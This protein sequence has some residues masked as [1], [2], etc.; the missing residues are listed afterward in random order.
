MEMTTVLMCLHILT[1][2][3]L[4][5]RVLSRPELNPSI[6]VLWIFIVLALPVGGVLLYL[7]VGEVHFG[8]S[9]LK[10][11]VAAEVA[12]RPYVVASGSR[13]DPERFSPAS[14]FATSI[15]GFGVTEG[16]RGELLESPAGARERLIADMD[17][18]VESI[19]V[20]YYIWLDD[21]TGRNVAAALERAAGRG[22][23]C[24]AL[25]DAVGSRA[26]L[27][28]ATWK[29]LAEAGVRT[30]VMLPLKPLLLTML[31]RR[32]DLRNHRK[33]SVIDGRVCYCG[34]QNCADSEFRVKPRF[35]PWVDI[36]LRFEGPVVRQMHLL[37]LKDWITVGG[38]DALAGIE[39]PVAG[40]TGGFE[41]QVVGTGPVEGRNITA[42]LFT[43]LIFGARHEL[44]I[45]T[46]YF[47]PGE[48]VCLALMGAARS[49]VDVTLILPRRNDSGFV[50][51]ASRSY[52]PALVGAGVKIHE[53]NGGLLHSKTL[54][55]DG[56]LAFVG[57]SNMDIRSFDLNF[58]NDILLRD[59]DLTLA[60]RDRQMEYLAASTPVDPEEVRAWP[61]WR[62]VWLNAFAVVGPVL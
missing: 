38:G 17:A 8:G 52:Y 3:A 40:F 37:F 39:G 46:P 18:A 54:T 10:R 23:R 42:Q 4:V 21:G 61:L 9:A 44:V 11:N 62:R 12:V 34:S 59:R 31:A 28:S 1:F 60:V 33:I 30:G 25:V 15:N 14:G 2:A 20:L 16:N 51:K 45:S 36:M 32:P 58:E 22:V 50:A 19:D 49:G 57:S 29:R 6:R 7:L 43:R 35:A 26:F 13:R 53:F 27:K 48:M 5:L 55:V 24:R 47:V 41:A 56:E